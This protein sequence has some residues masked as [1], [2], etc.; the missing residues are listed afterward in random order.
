MH[1]WNGT[2]N[3]SL[4]PPNRIDTIYPD[5]SYSRL[6]HHTFDPSPSTK[7][8]GWSPA[9]RFSVSSM[10]YDAM[11]MKLSVGNKQR[12]NKKSN[13]LLINHDKPRV[14]PLI[15]IEMIWPCNLSTVVALNS[16]YIFFWLLQLVDYISWN[17]Q[18]AKKNA[19]LWCPI[20]FPSVEGYS[21]D[22]NQSRV[23]AATVDQHVD[24]SFVGLPD[25]QCC[26]WSMVRC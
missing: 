19:I 8:M 24:Q 12:E 7:P 13:V 5:T 2:Q 26:S 6:H 1:I 4:K 9:T 20:I 15:A 21:S 10:V 18:V 16:S 25:A 14:H 22:E 23:A 17:K 11:L 3:S